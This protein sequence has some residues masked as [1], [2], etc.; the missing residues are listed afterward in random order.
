M[1]KIVLGRQQRLAAL[2]CGAASCV[3]FVAFVSLMILMPHSSAA[4]MLFCLVGLT[5][6][7]YLIGGRDV[8][9]PAF[10]FCA[11]WSLATAVYLLCPLEI[12][13]LVWKTVLIFVGGAICFTLGSV[14]GNRPLAKRKVVL[15]ANPASSRLGVRLLLLYCLIVLPFVVL[16][17]ARLAGQSIFSPEFFIASKE[18][19]TNSDTLHRSKILSSASV[20][21]VHTAWLLLLEG[22]R[23]LLVL[24]GGCS[25]AIMCLLGGTRGTLLP[26]IAGCL[27]VV[28]FRQSNRTL[29]AVGMKIAVVAVAVVLL[30]TLLSL[31]I[32]KE[33]QGAN[34]IQVAVNMSTA[35]VAGPLA[36]FNY[37]V[38]HPAAFKD[39]PWNTLTQ[40]VSP[41]VKGGVINVTLP[42]VNED[43]INIP[44]PFNVF[45]IYKP[46][47]HDLGIIG[48]MVVLFLLGFIYGFIFR[49]TVRGNRM[50]LFLFAALTEPLVMSIFHDPFN[51]RLTIF[52]FTLGFALFYFQVLR[53]L[54]RL[55][56]QHSHLVKFSFHPVWRRQ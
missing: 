4:L 15:F 52:V 24:L 10:I 42:P 43:F 7:N 56:F 45:T 3:A 53:R 26:L 27:V 5:G 48:C 2:L 6:V 35:Y 20:I 13:N 28:L 55:K 50:A 18:A 31:V 1:P 32:K 21:A 16:D 40:L 9:Y 14:I 37:Q 44:F 51:Y 29:R 30:M 17:T 38:T 49:A 25:A 23:K 8:L 54:P 12:D 34:G 47:Y 41:L 19:F 36:A 22:E 46:Y 11:T 33:T 39:Q